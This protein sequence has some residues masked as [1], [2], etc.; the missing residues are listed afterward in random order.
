MPTL[1]MRLDAPLQ[2]WGTQSNFGHR[3]T[4]LEPSKSG[5]IGLIGAAQGRERSAD[6]SDLA[7]LRMG[8]RVDREGTIVRD[9]HTAGV[10]GYYRIGGGVERSS[11][12]VSDRFILSDALFLVGLEGD[13]ALLETIQAALQAPVYPLF[14]GRKAFMPASPVWL[15][16]GVQAGDL[17]PMLRTYRWLGKRGTPAER[18]R[19]VIEDPNGS[20]VRRD[21]PVSFSPRRFMTRRVTI[22]SMSSEE[23]ESHV[24]EPTDT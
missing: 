4:G 9:Y 14:L 18:L 19:L 7:M 23:M 24:P 3:D 15:E 17:L 2:S 13:P 8:V 6:F 21:H 11:V 16:D 20:A 5:V 10:D 12:M 1:L 22:G